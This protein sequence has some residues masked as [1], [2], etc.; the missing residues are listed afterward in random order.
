MSIFERIRERIFR[1]EAQAADGKSPPAS[2]DTYVMP[3]E[4]APVP[5]AV[6][7]ATPVPE[8]P[9]ARH[10]DVSAI[11]AEKARNNPQQLNWQTSIVDLMKLLDLDSSLQNRR[12]LARELGYPA[13][14][15]DT[16]EMNVW[17]HREVMQR[18]QETGGRVPDALR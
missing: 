1:R 10:V 17:L 6:P 12:Q 4:T 8:P 13:D 7:S 3:A 18:L 16:A 9:P 14:T 2:S 15:D 5:S 11:L